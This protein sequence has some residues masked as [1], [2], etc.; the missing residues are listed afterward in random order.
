[1]NFKTV[2][3]IFLFFLGVAKNATTAQ[4]A[5]VYAVH[6]GDSYKVLID[7]AQKKVWVRLWG[8]DCPEVISNLIYEDQPYGRFVADTV[9][10]ILKGNRV[11]VDSVGVD[12]YKRPIVKV[13]VKDVDFTEFLLK[14]GWAW[15]F[16][17]GT[18]SLTEFSELLALQY[19]A[20]NKKLGLWADDE[21]VS[22]SRWRRLYRKR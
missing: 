6:D 9:R 3:F 8:V 13:K 22:P 12:I 2:F 11:T 17:N 19:E 14:N 1:M 10:T 18:I 5:T 16:N 21:R 7:G 20:S 4:N 15:P